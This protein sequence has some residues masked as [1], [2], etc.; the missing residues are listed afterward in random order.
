MRRG[1]DGQVSR[2][3][4]Y[5]STSARALF[6]LAACLWSLGYAAEF[7]NPRFSPNEEYL[8]FDYCQAK[9]QFAVYSLK[10]GAAITF[11]APKGESWINPSFGPKGDH[12]VFVVIREA[13]NTQLATI[14][15]DGTGFR[16]LTESAVI[17]RSPR[18]KGARLEL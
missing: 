12:V 1:T 5:L 10:T 4:A 7:G 6:A 11:D 2:A 13:S 17:K 9:C 16:K 8:A 15:L 3:S 18:T 14:K